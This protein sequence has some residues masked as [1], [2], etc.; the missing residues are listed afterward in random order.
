LFDARWAKYLNKSEN[1]D[2]GILP[3]GQISNQTDLF[4][5]VIVDDK[6]QLKLRRELRVNMHYRAV[7]PNV[8]FVLH[9]NYGGGPAVTREA[10]DIYS[11][12]MSQVA[13]LSVNPQSLQLLSKFVHGL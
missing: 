3:P 9:R 2:I 13:K 8:W 6:C 12:D 4:K 5:Q 11:K 1:L 10:L 7:N